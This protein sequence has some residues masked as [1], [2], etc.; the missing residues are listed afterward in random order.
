LGPIARL[1]S[2]EENVSSTY[3]EPLGTAKWDNMEVR[4]T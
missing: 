2:I 1:L 4:A 3:I